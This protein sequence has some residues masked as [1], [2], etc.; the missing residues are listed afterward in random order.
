MIHDMHVFSEGA[1]L[2]LPQLV[3]SS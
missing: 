2:V 3:W 1:A